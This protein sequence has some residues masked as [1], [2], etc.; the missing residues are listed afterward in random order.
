MPM[1]APGDDSPIDPPCAGLCFSVS[2]PGATRT[3]QNRVSPEIGTQLAVY[4]PAMVTAESLAPVG[5]VIVPVIGA[6]LRKCP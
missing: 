4:D 1:T 5:L 2:A 3:K 6:P